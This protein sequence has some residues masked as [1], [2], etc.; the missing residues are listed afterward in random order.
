MKKYGFT[1][2]EMLLSMAIIGVIS[3]LVIPNVMTNYQKKVYLT[4]LRKINNDISSAVTKYM[5][6]QHVDNL[7]DSSITDNGGLRSFI[8]NYFEIARD[9]GDNC[10]KS[11]DEKCFAKDFSPSFFRPLSVSWFVKF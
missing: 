3:A 8:T 4:E 1:L 10:Y 11:E 7:E 9:C 6:A 2:N 5:A